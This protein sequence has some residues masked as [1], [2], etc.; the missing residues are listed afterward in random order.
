MTLVVHDLEQGVKENRHSLAEQQQMT[1]TSE[2]PLNLYG[3]VSALRGYDAVKVLSTPV[4]QL[5]EPGL[6]LPSGL[7]LSYQ[8]GVGGEDHAFLHAAVVFGGDFPV[9]ELKM[10]KEESSHF[11]MRR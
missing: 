8:G 11:L 3:R 5:L 4:Q 6:V 10:S 7:A 2:E 1:K 9:F